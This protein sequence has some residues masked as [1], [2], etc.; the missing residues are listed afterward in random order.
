MFVSQIIDEVLDILG[1]T[2]K[3]KAYRKL[4]QAVQI[5]MQSG[6]WFHTNAEV[7]VCTG[8]DNQTIT[9]PRNIEVPLAV[10]VDGSPTYFRGRL[11]Q[12]HVNKGGMY[13][14]VGWAWDDRGMV[15][16]QMDIR[17]PSQLV[18]VAEHAA[19]AG[20]VIRVMGP[21][22]TN[23]AFLSQMK[24]GTGV[25]GLLWPITHSPIF[26]TARFSLMGSR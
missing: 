21:D 16:T 24:T 4:T 23:R 26:L 17:Q 22:G 8:W 10:N 3:P 25:D 15:A 13:N 5:L 9:L 11:F 20:K 7:D 2:D 14:P 6:H 19:D 1:T 18:A 12:Y